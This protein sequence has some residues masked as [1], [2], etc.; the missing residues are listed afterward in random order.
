MKGSIRL[1]GVALAAA[2]VAAITVPL[3]APAGAALTPSVTCA[4]LVSPPLKNGKSTGT[5]SNCTPAALAAGATSAFTPPPAG[6]QKGSLTGTYTWKNAKGKTIV[7]VQFALQATR[8]KCPAGTTRV[9]STGKVTG[10]SGAAAKII[11]KGEPFTASVCA[12][13]SGAKSGQ[14]LNEPGTKVK[15]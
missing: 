5:L 11:K 4:K 7:L 14:T 8:G 9:K 3:V 13:T 1:R 2:A 15:M 10:G 6:S 12:Y